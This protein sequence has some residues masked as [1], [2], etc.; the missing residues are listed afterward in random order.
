MAMVV[1]LVAALAVASRLSG[2]SG[3]DSVTHQESELGRNAVALPRLPAG[4]STEPPVSRPS[5][6][7]P[8]PALP[9]T[10]SPDEYVIAIAEIVFGLNTRDHSRQDYVDLLLGQIS[11]EAVGGDRDRIEPVTAAWIPDEYQWS[12]QRD[13]RQVSRFSAEHVWVP[14]EV[15]HAADQIP[16]AYRVRTVAGTQTAEFLDENGHTSKTTMPRL[17]TVVAYCPDAGVCSLLSIA[18]Q[19]L[20]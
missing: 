15:Q 3:P 6:G 17:L 1:G 12:R 14:S 10:R 11:D 13:D 19:V 2:G 7:R 9:A 4:V 5:A 20:R 16:A 8:L 18:K